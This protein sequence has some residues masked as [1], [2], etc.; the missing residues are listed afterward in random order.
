M[1]P[2]RGGEEAKDGVASLRFDSVCYVSKALSFKSSTLVNCFSR[3]AIWKQLWRVASPV[4]SLCPVSSSPLQG[5]IRQS[6]RQTVLG[7]TLSPQSMDL[8]AS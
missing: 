1:G 4:V 7:E 5:L 6:S 2:R 3:M 8:L